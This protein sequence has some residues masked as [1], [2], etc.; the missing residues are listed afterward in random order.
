MLTEEKSAL[1]LQIEA[2]LNEVRPFLEVDGGN[3]EL[4]D[5]TE[6]WTVHVKWLGNCQS[7]SMSSMTMKA[8]IE[9]AIKSKIPQ[10]QSVIAINDILNN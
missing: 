8:G 6:D 5:V 3:I 4:V 1:F 9:Q 2:A 10:V 7:C